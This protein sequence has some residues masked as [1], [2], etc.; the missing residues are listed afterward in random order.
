MWQS[1]EMKNMLCPPS[2]LSFPVPPSSLFFPL[3]FLPPSVSLSLGLFC[4]LACGFLLKLNY[5]HSHFHLHIYGVLTREESS[6]LAITRGVT[7]GKVSSW[8]NWNTYPFTSLCE[9]G[10]GNYNEL[11]LGH[12][13]SFFQVSSFCS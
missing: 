9:L 6:F 12:K 3:S 2:L 5:D 4:L 13:L 11:S 7:L 1:R 8:L 10:I